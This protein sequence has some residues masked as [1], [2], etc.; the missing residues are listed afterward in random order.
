M[1][2]LT[3]SQ[4]EELEKDLEKKQSKKFGL[5]Q[6]GEVVDEPAPIVMPRIYRDSTRY[7]IDVFCGKCNYRLR[8]ISH[9]QI[10]QQQA[11]MQQRMG[12][13]TSALGSMSS[14]STQFVQE[15]CPHCGTVNQGQIYVG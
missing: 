5:A 8:S 6:E 7:A 2:L 9:Q 1:Q 12:G 13:L 14:G 10:L 15:S 11:Y 4:L 3:N